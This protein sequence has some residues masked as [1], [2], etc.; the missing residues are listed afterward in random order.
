MA[1]LT[2]KALINEFETMLSEMPF[3]KITVSALIAR[4]GVSSNTFYYHY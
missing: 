3:S 4:C 1:K 2:Q